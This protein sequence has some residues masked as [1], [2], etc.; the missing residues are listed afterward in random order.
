MV[1]ISPPQQLLELK[2][3]DES[4]DIVQFEQVES[5]HVVSFVLEECKTMKFEADLDRVYEN[6]VNYPVIQRSLRD[7]FSV[8]VIIF[9][10]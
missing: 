8:T 5:D 10:S 4:K 6:E 9:T 1:L 3:F 2:E 7:M